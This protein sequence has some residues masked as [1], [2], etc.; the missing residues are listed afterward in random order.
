MYRTLPRTAVAISS[1]LT[2]PSVRTRIVGAL[3]WAVALYLSL[4]G[5]VLHNDH[6]DRISRARQLARFGELPFRDY[7]DPGY[8]GSVLASAA[9][10]RLLGD[11]LLGELL[12]NAAFIATGTVLVLHLATRLSRSLALGAAAALLALLTMP[13]A[14]DYDK[15]LFFPLGVALCWRYQDTRRPRDLVLLA[16]ALVCGAVFRYDTGVYIGG[17][18]IAA[19]VAAHAPDWRTMAR[20]AGLLAASVAAAA[21]P[22]LLFVALQGGL[23]DAVDQVATYARREAAR[24]RITAPPA[25]AIEGPLLAFGRLPRG[26]IVNVRWAEGMTPQLREELEA[27]YHLSEGRIEGPAANPTW[28]YAIEDLVHC[29]RPRARRGPTGG[30]HTLHRPDD[31]RTD[32]YGAALQPHPPASAVASR[33]DRSRP[34][35]EPQCCP[36]PVPTC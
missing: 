22:V 9:L 8:F 21:S 26:I 13:R 4:G 7:F 10:Q 16:I 36:H 17:G 24:T 19:V 29:Q 11:N 34:V 30:R 31:L 25:M 20:R 2:D 23:P 12:L 5:L 28:V 14:Y 35:G 1:G 27:R 32:Q 18:A 33:R 15:V 6:F 3:L